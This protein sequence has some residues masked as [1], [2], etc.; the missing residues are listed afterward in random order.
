M[1][2]SIGIDLGTSGVKAVLIDEAH[3]VRAVASQPIAVSIPQVGWSEQSPELWVSAV[4]GCM[5]ELAA[6]EPFLTK[7]VN[8]ALTRVS[9]TT[10]W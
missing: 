4:I 2:L 1:T 8:A 9:D 5:D 3:R 7:A 6:T 10:P